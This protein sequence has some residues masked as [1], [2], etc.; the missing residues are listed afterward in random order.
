MQTSEDFLL[1]PVNTGARMHIYKFFMSSMSLSQI[2]KDNG[3]QERTLTDVIADIFE[4][5]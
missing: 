4:N 1:L 2:N 5:I 3:K